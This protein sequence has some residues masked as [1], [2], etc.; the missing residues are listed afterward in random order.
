MAEKV[1]T[2]ADDNELDAQFTSTETVREL[3]GMHAR[4]DHEVTRWEKEL[5]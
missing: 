5:G 1:L 3:I 4:F 2:P